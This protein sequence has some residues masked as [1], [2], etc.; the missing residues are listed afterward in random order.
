MTIE[1]NT[2][3]RNLILHFENF[4]KNVPKSAFEQ[5]FKTFSV[6]QGNVLRISN[7]CVKLVPPLAPFSPY[8]S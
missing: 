4:A 7:L 1:I 8:A 2:T 5:N 3:N 6:N